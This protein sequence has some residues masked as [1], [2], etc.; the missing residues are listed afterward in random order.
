MEVPINN[1]EQY[2]RYKNITYLDI[3]SKWMSRWTYHAIINWKRDIT[4]NSFKKLTQIFHLDKKEL[5]PL[6]EK[7]MDKK[8]NNIK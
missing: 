5:L 1:L 7:T 3:E 8:D 4:D 6:I 2:R